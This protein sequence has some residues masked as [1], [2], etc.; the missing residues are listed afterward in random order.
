MVTVALLVVFLLVACVTDVK[1]HKIY[2]WTVYPGIVTGLVVNLW[3]GG[4]DGSWNKG[5]QGLQESGIGFLVCGAVMLV[6]FVFFDVGGGDVKLVAM[7]G[8]FL[9]TDAG[10]ESMLWTFILGSI[11]GV[12]ILIWQLGFVHI[13]RKTAHHLKLILMVKGWIP[14]TEAERVPLGRWLFLAPS[15]LVAVCLVVGR[16]WLRHP[17]F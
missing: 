10:V 16:E 1:F 4:W 11:M 7:M 13:L 15:G 12:A 17:P 2:N 3:L 14:L 8:A 6:C 9:G 5:W